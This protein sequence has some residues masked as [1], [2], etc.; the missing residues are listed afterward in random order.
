MCGLWKMPVV[1]RGYLFLLCVGVDGN[2]WGGAVVYGGGLGV[3]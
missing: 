1:I 2:G 3:G